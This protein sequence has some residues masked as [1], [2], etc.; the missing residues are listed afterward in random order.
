MNEFKSNIGWP[1]LLLVGFVVRVVLSSN[2]KIAN[3]IYE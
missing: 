3:L 1:S 2:A